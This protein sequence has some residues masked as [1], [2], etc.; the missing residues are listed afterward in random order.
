MSALPSPL[1]SCIGGVL[2]TLT[3]TSVPPAPSDAVLAAQL[4]ALRF[5]RCSTAPSDRVIVPLV[6]PCPV[7]ELMVTV[8]PS[9]S[10]QFVLALGNDSGF[11][12]TISGLGVGAGGPKT[13]F[14]DHERPTAPL[15]PATGDANTSGTLNLADR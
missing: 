1:K 5:V 13:H 12:D 10:P 7:S 9:I 14:R 4:A 11:N 3:N 15:R 8:W 2:A 6:V